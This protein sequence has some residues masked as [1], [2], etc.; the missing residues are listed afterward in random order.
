MVATTLP[1]SRIVNT[2]VAN[3]SRT[4]PSP[5]AVAFRAIQAA[6]LPAATAGY[7]LW[8]A[9]MIRYRKVSGASATVLATVYSRW[10]QHQLGTRQDEPCARLMAVLPNAPPFALW[11]FTAPTLLGHHLTRFIPRIYRYPY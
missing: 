8:I 4:R 10:M 11:L 6:L 9:S 5:A 1:S 3:A 7:L 2:D